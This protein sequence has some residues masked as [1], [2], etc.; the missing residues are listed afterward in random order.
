MRKF[1][2]NVALMASLI[3]LA[4]GLWQDWGVWLTLKRTLISYMGFSCGSFL[5]LVIWAIP[6]QA[7]NPEIPAANRT[8]DRR[9][10]T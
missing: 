4:V 9:P 8:A 10:N 3:A 5:V 7:G 6:L 2:H 1:I